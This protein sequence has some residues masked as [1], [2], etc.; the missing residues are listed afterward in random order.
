MEHLGVLLLFA[1][2]VAIAAV[3]FGI[4]WIAV[5]LLFGR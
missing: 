1:A 2:I 5:R 4:G 3:G